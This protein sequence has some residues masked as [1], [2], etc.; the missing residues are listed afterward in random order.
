M[1]RHS[2]LA[3][4]AVTVASVPPAPLRAQSLDGRSVQF[5]L[6]GGLTKPLGDLSPATTH[7]ANAGAL[8]TIGAPESNLRF[9]LDGQWQQLTG[10][11]NSI[12]LACSSCISATYQR[13]FR[14]LDATANAVYSV[15]LSEPVR[16]YAIGGAGVYNVR[17]TV[18]VH[19]D[20][21]LTGE[22][23]AVTRLGFNAGAG[24]SL[25]LGHLATFVEARIHNLLGDH[26]YES[27]GYS[28][29]LPG[30]FQFVPFSGGIVF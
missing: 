17:G 24:L 4:V 15:R 10:K 28:G 7:A 2:L 19:Q 26:A 3:L 27:D 9:R 14:I 23:T 21:V 30:A 5:G 18:L 8:V 25:R 20:A 6:M 1:N 11:T 12:E 16:L 29:A 22:R 13:N